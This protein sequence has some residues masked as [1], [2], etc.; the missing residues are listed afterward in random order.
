MFA[1][2]IARGPARLIAASVGG[3]A[4]A[5]TML[6]RRPMVQLDARPVANRTDRT[7]SA[8]NRNS[9]L[10][11]D[12]IRQVSSGSVAGFLAGFATALLSQTLVIIGSVIAISFYVSSR[13]G[14]DLSRL[15]RLDRVPAVSAIYRAGMKNPWFTSAFA[16]TYVL[17][18][19]ARI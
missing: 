14:L 8:P 15:L 17:A 10:T 19:F 9:F 12:N 5:C 6:L 1:N 3:G 11:Q 13:Y 7:S 16:L 4:C 2:R 18:A